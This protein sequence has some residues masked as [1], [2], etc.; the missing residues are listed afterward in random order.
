[1]KMTIETTDL[2]TAMVMLNA[3]SQREELAQLMLELRKIYKYSDSEQSV[4]NLAQDI[5][6]RINLIR[7]N[8]S[9][10]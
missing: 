2:F 7:N 10:N 5:Y 3:M 9:E 4:K 1:M 8:V 6:H